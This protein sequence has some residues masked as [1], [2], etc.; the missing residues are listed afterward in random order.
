MKN[1]LHTG[2]HCTVLAP[3]WY[4]TIITYKYVLRTVCTNLMSETWCSFSL[5]VWRV[6][7]CNKCRV[8]P[9]YQEDSWCLAC[10]AVEALSSELRSRW[11]LPS[12]REAAE[13]SI[14]ST[15]RQV[16][17]LRRLA[18]GLAAERAATKSREPAKSADAALAVAPS[19]SP[20]P[21]STSRTPR[22][23]TVKVEEKAERDSG[24]EDEEG[25]SYTEE[26]GDTLPGATRL[27]S[28]P[29]DPSGGGGD[30]PRGSLPTPEPAGPPPRSSGKRRRP[31]DHTREGGQRRKHRA[32]ARHKR[33]SRLVEN[34]DTRVHRSFTHHNSDEHA[35]RKTWCVASPKKQWL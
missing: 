33:L 24:D 28:R 9:P 13:E 15:A 22:A 16:K 17:S 14:I 4:G 29:S 7:L 5:K 8:N 35:R 32:G 23:E 30:R 27:P 1:F 10:S 19:R 2:A 34:P 31:R 25:E 26:E 12:L 11:E 20:L 3:P 6:M 18:I 21:R